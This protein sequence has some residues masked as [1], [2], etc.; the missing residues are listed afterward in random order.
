VLSSIIAAK[1]PGPLSVVRQREEQER[2]RRSLKN[3]P[4]DLRSIVIDSL[5][6]GRSTREIAQKLGVSDDVVARRLV[7]AIDL[8]RRSLKDTTG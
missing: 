7:K 5:Y 2:V 6:R 3:L 1:G 8:L 4:D